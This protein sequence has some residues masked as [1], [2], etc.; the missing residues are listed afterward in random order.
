VATAGAVLVGAA[1]PG[2][3]DGVGVAAA[4]PLEPC[5]PPLEDPIQASPVTTSSRA[6]PAPVHSCHRRLSGG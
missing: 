2:A 5:P 1:A 4:R 3:E 6:S